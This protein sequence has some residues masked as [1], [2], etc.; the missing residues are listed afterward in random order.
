MTTELHLYDF[1][2]TLFRSPDRPSWW[3]RSTWAANPASLGRPC[4]PDKP[5][6]DWWISSIVSSAK[7]S[8][9]DQDV[10]AILCTGRWGIGTSGARWRVPELLKQAGLNFD[11]VYLNDTGGDTAKY[12]LAVFGKVLRRHPK[13]DTVQIWEDHAENLP[14]YVNYVE[15]QGLTAVPHFVR[16]TSHETDCTEDK[17]LE[18]VAEGWAVWNKRAGRVAAS[19]I[20]RV[21]RRDTPESQQ[22]HADQASQE[23]HVTKATRAFKRLLRGL[24]PHADQAVTA[25]PGKDKQSLQRRGR[26]FIKA[27][28]HLSEVQGYLDT[29]ISTETADPKARSWRSA[30]LYQARN[31]LVYGKV[32][33]AEAL[34]EV[35]K[36]AF[37]GFQSITMA[38]AQAP[39]R[40]IVPEEILAYL[41]KNL[42]VEVD[43]HGF[44][45]QVTDRFENEHETL[46]VKI[47]RQK[48]LLQRYN[49]IA[50]AVKTD[51]QSSDEMTKLS[52]LITAIIMETGIRPGEAGNGVVKVVNGKD[53]EIETFGAITLGPGHVRFVRSKFAELEF[54]GKKGGTN[55][56]KVA[57]REILKVLQQYVKQALKKGTKFIFVTSK[58]QRYTYTDLQRYFREQITGIIPTDFRKLRATAAV[59]EAL[60]AEQQNLY[61]RIKDFAGEQV[62]DLKQRVAHEIATAI[63]NAINTAQAAL[64]HESAGT[65]VRA[66][67]NPSII[68]DFLDVGSVPETLEKVV[69]Q[70]S[71]RLGFD[72]QKFVSMAKF[73]AKG[74]TAIWQ[75]SPGKTA[76]LGDLL[77]NLEEDMDEEGVSVP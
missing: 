22:Y 28:R 73:L 52:A 19:W 34:V 67:I 65:T 16:S 39:L 46:G 77:N 29:W 60:H 59:L 69:L 68:L 15:R 18:M 17:M 56:A 50:K 2:G 36:Q 64:S 12:K 9:A 47:K 48:D 32:K 57:D 5:G 26:T 25:Y 14:V 44:I 74:K 37:K 40:E 7:R 49:D 31:Y 66:Y 70:N 27:I 41:P 55:L 11:E 6:A 10:W 35:G 61:A 51:L 62:D 58:G 8:I 42:V 72:P 76:S 53:E 30:V 21:A 23:A 54:A 4:V 45:Q 43:E 33:L 20:S 13:I 1:D 75:G 71:P 38:E 24:K 3:G 63:N